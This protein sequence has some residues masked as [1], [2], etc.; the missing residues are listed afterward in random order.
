MQP[1]EKCLLPLM[2][3]AKDAVRFELIVLRPCRPSQ[4]HLTKVDRVLGCCNIE[5]AA[6]ILFDM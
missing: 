6:K 2:Y 3:A 5:Q 4:K 1:V